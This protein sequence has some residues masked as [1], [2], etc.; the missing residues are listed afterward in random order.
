MPRKKK[1]AKPPMR[2]ASEDIM[3]AEPGDFC[4]Y[5]NQSNKPEFA[6][7][8]RVFDEQGMRIFRIMTQVDFKFVCVPALICSFDEKNLKGKKRHI[9][10][11]GVY[12][13]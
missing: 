6:E 8:K 4:Y 11:P 2:E 7:I 3:T 1:E 5:L 9:L 12:R 10:C 13:G